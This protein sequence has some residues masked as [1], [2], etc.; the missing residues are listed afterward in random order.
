MGYVVTGEEVGAEVWKIM[1]DQQK[2]EL[3][4]QQE[5]VQTNRE[6]RIELEYKVHPKRNTLNPTPKT[7]NPKP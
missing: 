7:L 3:D 2:K 4:N 1:A 6:A 5:E